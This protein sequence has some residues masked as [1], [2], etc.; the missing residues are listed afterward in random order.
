M[1]S[2]EFRWAQPSDIALICDFR[3][4][5]LIDEGLDPSVN[6]DKNM[7]KFF[8]EGLKNDRFVEI[9]A[10]LDEEIAATGGLCFYDYPPSYS[11]PTGKTAYITNMYTVPRFRKRGLAMKI[12]DALMA[13]V[14]RRDIGIV[15]LRASKW[16]RFVYEKY[17][18]ETRKDWMF[19]KID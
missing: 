5:Q 2:L 15:W 16:G 3:K 7:E 4:R 9:F 13:E 12:L 19:F 11:N 6:I 10:V 1:E 17:G 8:T 18:F 14:R